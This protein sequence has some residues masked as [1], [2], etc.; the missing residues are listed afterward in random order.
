MQKKNPLLRIWGWEKN[1]PLYLPLLGIGLAG[2]VARRK[3]GVALAKEIEIKYRREGR[4][5]DEILGGDADA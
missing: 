3:E 1:M 4:F 2:Y 5:F